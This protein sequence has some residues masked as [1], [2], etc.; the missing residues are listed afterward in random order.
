MNYY[1][2][3]YEKNNILAT[4]Q[5]NLTPTQSMLFLIIFF[6][7]IAISIIG[8]WKMFKK[9]GEEGWKSLIPIYNM[10]ILFKI[11]GLSPYLLFIFLAGIIPVVGIYISGIGSFILAIL[12]CRHVAKSFGKSGMFAVGVFFFSTIFYLILGF[13]KAEYIGPNGEKPTTKTPTPE[14]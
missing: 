2:N 9:A 7:L 10:V 5:N 13:G 4:A 14:V 8:I 3:L 6:V 11:I 1:D 12:S